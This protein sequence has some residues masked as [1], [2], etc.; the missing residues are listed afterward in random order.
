V[1]KSVRVCRE[2]GSI[3]GACVQPDAGLV[4]FLS[5][6]FVFPRCCCWCFF[7]AAS[8]WVD[9]ASRR[10]VIGLIFVLADDR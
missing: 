10:M 4:R 1:E 7:G 2:R 5:A 6:H 9:D 3:C 8:S